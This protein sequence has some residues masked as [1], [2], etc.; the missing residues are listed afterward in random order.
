[1]SPGFFA[2]FGHKLSSLG[3]L[4]LLPVGTRGPGHLLDDTCLSRTGRSALALHHLGLGNFGLRINM[5]ELR[6]HLSDTG[7]L[8]EVKFLCGGVVSDGTWR[9]S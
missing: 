3:E 6:S 8:R 5:M 4:E 1:M 7:H 9:I 2:G